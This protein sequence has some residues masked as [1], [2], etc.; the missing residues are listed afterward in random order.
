MRAL[1]NRDAYLRGAVSAALCH[2][3]ASA[4]SLSGSDR[5]ENASK[6]SALMIERGGPL[7]VPKAG[8]SFTSGRL[9]LIAARVGQKLRRDGGRVAT[10][11]NQSPVSVLR[12]R[13]APIFL[14]QLGLF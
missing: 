9:F 4:F 7:A 12:A 13:P 10:S 8:R 11:W 14:A 5:T 6:L 1:G 2:Q 3:P